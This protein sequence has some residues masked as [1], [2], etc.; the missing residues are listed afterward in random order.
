MQKLPPL[1]NLDGSS[2]DDHWIVLC[3]ALSRAALLKNASPTDLDLAQIIHREFDFPRCDVLV[4]M[5][6]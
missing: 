3:Y 5:C 6:T 2:G 4:E 1:R